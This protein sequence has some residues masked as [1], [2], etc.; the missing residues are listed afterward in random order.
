MTQQETIEQIARRQL[1]VETLRTRNND[2]DDFHA[3]SVWSIADALNAAYEAGKLA[4]TK[5]K[6]RPAVVAG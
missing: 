1:S 3:L 5:S 4:G 6:R 2:R